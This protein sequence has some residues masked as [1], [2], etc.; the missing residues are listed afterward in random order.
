MQKQKN[1]KSPKLRDNKTGRW[2]P[3]VSGNPNGRPFGSRNKTTLAAISLLEGEAEMLTQRAIDAARNGDMSAL[4]LVLDRIIPPRRR[5]VVQI[6]LERLD[7]LQDAVQAHRQ[8]IQAALDGGLSL[9]EAERLS[10]LII[11]HLR[12]ADIA[13]NEWRA[14]RYLNALLK[15]IVELRSRLENLKI[16]NGH[17]AKMQ[18]ENNSL[19][20][21]L[22]DDTDEAILLYVAAFAYR[23]DCREHESDIERAWSALPSSERELL[24]EAEKYFP[25]IEIPE[26]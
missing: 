9:D 22:P 12:A 11:R 8:I 18:I 1:A 14:Q 23:Y 20:A 3:G 25:F 5:P 17:D 4:K 16:V 13:E 2:Q 26:E 7:D 21:K 10:K 6:D 24:R 19:S 15:R